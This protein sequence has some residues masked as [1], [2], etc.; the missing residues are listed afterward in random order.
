L[1]EEISN[2]RNLESL[3]SP[4]PPSPH[5]LAKVRQ[6]LHATEAYHAEEVFDVIL[7][8]NDQATKVMELGQKSF[9]L[10]TPTVAPQ[11]TAILSGFPALSAMRCDHLDALAVSQISVQAVAAV[12]FIADQ[13][14]LEGVEE[15]VPEDAFDELTFVRRSAFDTNG[16][17]RSALLK[18][19]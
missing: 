7:P 5:A 4:S 9:H 6:D 16:E 15:G 11:G 2:F 1:K 18:S 12:S 14:G 10:P 19:A 13:S 8:T 3:P 17:R